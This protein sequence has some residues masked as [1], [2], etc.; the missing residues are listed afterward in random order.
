M[1]YLTQELEIVDYAIENAIVSGTFAEMEE[2]LIVWTKVRDYQKSKRETGVQ[3]VVRS[4]DAAAKQDSWLAD[5]KQWDNRKAA[6]LNEIRLNK[7]GYPVLQG[8]LTTFVYMNDGSTVVFNANFNSRIASESHWLN[9]T[10]RRVIVV[11]TSGTTEIT[12]PHRIFELTLYPTLDA[13]YLESQKK[14][15]IKR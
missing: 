1:Y 6:F 4:G 10:P 8:G 15:P 3:M 2:S 12:A 14:R 7:T 11:D 5:K 13:L 9:D